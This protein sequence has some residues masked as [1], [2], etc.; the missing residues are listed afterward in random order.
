MLAYTKVIDFCIL[1]FYLGVLLNSPMSSDS[2]FVD[3]LRPYIGSCSYFLQI[4]PI[5]FLPFQRFFSGVSHRLRQCYLLI[6]IEYPKISLSSMTFAV[7]FQ[8]M[9]FIRLWY[10]LSIPSLLRL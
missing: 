8:E 1:I 10:F 3:S 7:G 5:L 9:S 2:L 4:M 6:V